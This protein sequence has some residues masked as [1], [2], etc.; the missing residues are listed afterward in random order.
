MTNGSCKLSGV[1]VAS[2]L[3][4]GGLLLGSGVAWATHSNECQ[5]EINNVKRVLNGG[6]GDN[7]D[8]VDLLNNRNRDRT[9]ASLNSKLD[10]AS[11]KLFQHKPDDALQKLE[12]F[13][14]KVKDLSDQGKLDPD[15]AD[16]LVEKVGFAIDC[17]L[18][19]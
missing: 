4:V 18:D 8:G 3:L 10:G 9:C 7:C 13:R 6:D 16:L 15:D 17:V 19:L 1:A 14:D 11:A 12:Q 5:A 2:A